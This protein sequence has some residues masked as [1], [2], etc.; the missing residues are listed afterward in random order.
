MSPTRKF[1]W[2]ITGQLKN[3][4]RLA[5]AQNPPTMMYVALTRFVLA[6][7]LL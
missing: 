3:C 2:L 4:R 7:L 1:F 6:L 5:R